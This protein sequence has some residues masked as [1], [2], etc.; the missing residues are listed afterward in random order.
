MKKA[1][2][3]CALGV[4]ALAVSSAR[5]DEFSFSFSGPSVDRT[6]QFSFSGSGTMYA[7]YSGVADVWNINSISGS[8]TTENY[9]GRFNPPTSTSYDIDALLPASPAT[10]SF[11]G[12]DN[13]LYFP[14]GISASGFDFF[15]TAGVSFSLVGTTNDVNLDTAYFIIFPYDQGTAG[16]QSEAITETVCWQG[17]GDPP[18]A[19]PEPGSLALLGTSILGGAGILRRRFKA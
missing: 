5:A 13:I 16:T 6:N 19:T 9:D 10:G 1:L 3:L 14:G 8:V 2:M 12:N 4:V 17:P 15:D 7:T 18:S 11:D